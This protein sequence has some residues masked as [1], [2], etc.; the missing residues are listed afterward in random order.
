MNKKIIALLLAVLII[1]GLFIGYNALNNKGKT[2]PIDEITSAYKNYDFYDIKNYDGDIFKLENPVV[3]YSNTKNS[4]VI[5]TNNDTLSVYLIDDLLHIMTLNNVDY[6]Y[7]TIGEVERMMSYNYCECKECIRLVI[8]NSE[9]NL[10]YLDVD[11][12]INYNNKNIFKK[13]ESDNY[14]VNIGYIENL[15]VNDECGVNGLASVTND[16]NLVI[17]DNN[18]N[19]FKQDYYSF[20]SNSASTLYIYPDGS[21]LLNKDDVEYNLNIKASNIFV[22]D[23]FYYAI[24]IDGYLYQIDLN[25]NSKKVNSNKIVKI[26]IHKKDDKIDKLIVIYNNASAKNYNVQDILV[27][28]SSND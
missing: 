10:Y 18:M 26:G 13:V 20:I 27:D 17:Y 19:E 16:N 21:L 24:S 22:S 2:N 23:D 14:Y 8:L 28:M 4:L 11:E 7:D 1:L 6:K 5:K 9:G 15:N 25:G 3:N 12:N